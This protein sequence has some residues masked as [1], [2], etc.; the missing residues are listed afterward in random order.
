M[1]ILEDTGRSW[2]LRWIAAGV[3]AF[4][5]LA[6]SLRMVAPGDDALEEMP[7]SVVEQGAGAD[8]GARDVIERQGAGASDESDSGELA[9]SGADAQPVDSSGASGAEGSGITLDSS[10]ADL[11]PLAADAARRADSGLAPRTPFDRARA[12]EVGGWVEG[13]RT[14]F[15]AI[16][17]ASPNSTEGRVAAVSA[18]RLAI[19]ADEPKAALDALAAFSATLAGGVSNDIG[20]GQIQDAD[21]GQGPGQNQDSDQDQG[22]GEIQ[23]SDRDQDLGQAQTDAQVHDQATALA[24]WPPEADYHLAAALAELGQAQPAATSFAR[25]AAAVPALADLAHRAAGDALLEAGLAA[26]AADAYALALAVPA[27]SSSSVLSAIKLGNA[28]LRLGDQDAAIEAYADAEQRAE[29]DVERAQAFAGM[30]AAHV[31]AGRT[32]E[33]NAVRRRL[34]QELLGT[35]TARASLERLR[36]AGIPAPPEEAAA[37][38][39]A[40][41]EHVAALVSIQLAIDARTAAG[42]STPSDWNLLALRTELALDDFEAVYTR[43]DALVASGASGARAAEVAMLRARALDEQDRDSEAAA[44]FLELTNAY[45]SSPEAVGALWRRTSL[46]EDLE[47]VIAG[48]DAHALFAARFPGDYR[49]HDAAFRAGW[50][51]WNSGRLDAALQTW[52]ALA[53]NSSAPPSQRARAEYWLGRI[54]AEREGPVAAAVRWRSAIEHEPESFH[55]LLAAERLGEPA[56]PAPAGTTADTATAIGAWLATWSSGVDQQ[57]FQANIAAVT[58]QTMVARGE[59]LLRLGE[60]RAARRALRAYLS[61]INGDAAR[62]AALAIYAESVDLPD[63]AIPAAAEALRLAPPGLRQTAPS[64]L[65]RLIYPLGDAALIRAEARAHGLPPAL[66]FALVWQ[67]SR[68]DPGAISSAGARGLT[69]VMPATGADI[70]DRL[71]DIGYD[72]EQL[73]RPHVSARYG[74]WYLS[75]QL[76]NLAD[77][78]RVALAAYNGGP[79][80]ARRWLEASAGDLD[81]FVESIHLSETRRYLPA[82]ITARAWY[83]RLDPADAQP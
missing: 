58:T 37:V 27:P 72:P 67:E 17:A 13:A 46:V 11:D 32:D 6:A 50:L 28:R 41:G 69:Q 4:V 31:D 25:Y 48:A 70:A 64:A 80:N 1:S 33:A 34:V 75:E 10:A 3:L 39:E 7:G 45:P 63:I 15:L 8:D 35:A 82:V 5:V 42:S 52:S 79:G 29:I 56:L 19:A 38:L 61:Q 47:G 9:S 81:A 74:A 23:D 36:E 2:R 68:F 60:G 71:G 77:D 57:R 26:E 21:Q 40:A 76:S 49:S 62:L 43:A 44:A 83:E 20:R 55:A 16:A 66:M 22:P 30:V 53:G 54:A 14:E 51:N 73:H 18:A 78:Q 59:A 24:E 65:R 12:L